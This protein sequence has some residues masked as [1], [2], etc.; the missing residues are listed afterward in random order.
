MWLA[1]QFRLPVILPIAIEGETFPVIWAV[2]GSAI[3]SAIV[4]L[5]T[6][7]RWVWDL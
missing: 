6:S 1:Q 4:G 2:I 3:F 5:L 7:R